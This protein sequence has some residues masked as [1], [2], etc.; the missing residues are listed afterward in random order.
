MS[1]RRG[2]ACV[3]KKDWGKGMKPGHQPVSAKLDRNPRAAR[4][5]AFHI[6]VAVLSLALLSGCEQNAFVPPP[7]PAVDVALPV[8]R[9]ITRYLEATGNT[10]PIKSVDLVARVQG[11]LQAIS[12]QDGAFVKEGTSLFTIEPETYRAQARTGAGGRS[13]RPGVAETGRGRLQAPGGPGRAP[14][15]L[16]GHP[17]SVHLGARQRPGQPAAGPGQHQDRRRQFRLHQCH[18]AV[19]RHRQ[20]PSHLG[21]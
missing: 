6:A 14:G 7:P 2:S 4:P 8:Q 18:R 13:G 19:R 16:A 5:G 10:A 20:R 12:Y 11:V 3:A 9:S 21:R 15:G 17:R 1:S